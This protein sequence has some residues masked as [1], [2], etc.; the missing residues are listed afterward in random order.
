MLSVAKITQHILKSHSASRQCIHAYLVGFPP[1]RFEVL[2]NLT[3]GGF[4]ADL[5]TVH[6]ED[7]LPSVVRGP[8]L[9]KRVAL[10]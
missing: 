2:L 1:S 10:K 3:E 5:N 8:L 7:L 6:I 4:Y 9:I